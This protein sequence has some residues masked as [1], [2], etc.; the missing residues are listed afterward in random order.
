MFQPPVSL[1]T[2]AMVDKHWG[3]N[4]NHA[5][6]DKAV[7]KL[8]LAEINGTSASAAY[9]LE[10]ESA[11]TVAKELTTT[12]RAAIPGTRAMLICQLNPMGSNT[13]AKA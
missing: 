11:Y 12:S 4:T 13:T 8:Q 10:L 1:L 5:N 9:P 2:A 7:A 3:A 6:N